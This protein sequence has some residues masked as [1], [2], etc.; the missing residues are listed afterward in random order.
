[1]N[2]NSAY[3]SN[4]LKADDLQGRAITLTIDRVE[5]ESV[6]QG[7]NKEEKPVVYFKGKEKGLVLNKTNAKTIANLYGGETDEWEGKAITIRPA[8]VE[9]Q[10]EMV[11]SIR[12][13][14]QK[15]AAGAP[16]KPVVAR[17]TAP[18]PEPED[19]ASTDIAPDDIPF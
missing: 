13:S 5:M 6:G 15:P 18:E 7:R 11:L 16:A 12:V 14:L 2:I 10:G 3:P 9:Y 17:P 8:E 19:P 1:M 4:Y